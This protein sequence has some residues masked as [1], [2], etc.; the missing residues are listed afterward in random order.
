MKTRTYARLALLIPLLIWVIF[1]LVELL[2]NAVIPDDLRPD[3]PTSLFGIVEI[4][5][6]YYVI[7]ILVWFIPYLILSIALLL[8]SFKS[9]LEV[10]KYAFVLSPFAMTILVMTEVTILS[11][12]TAGDAVPSMDFA[13]SFKEATGINLLVGILA[14]VWGYICVG[15][16]I[17]GY[18]LLQHFGMIKAEAEIQPQIISVNT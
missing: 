13:S 15:L 2:I 6:L 9:R 5:L 14:L 16:G 1:L 4:V 18:K 17:G 12:A 7:G 8:I 10:L 3:G 11:L